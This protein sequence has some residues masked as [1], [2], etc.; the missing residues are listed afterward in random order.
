MIKKLEIQIRDLQKELTEIKKNQAVLRLQPCLGDS[1]MR[2]KEDKFDELDRKAK[3]L[4]D[5]L[6]DTIRKRQLMLSQSAIKG[7][8]QSPQKVEKAS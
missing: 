5:T 3:V 7:A 2:E 6:R 1:E 4:T 8:C